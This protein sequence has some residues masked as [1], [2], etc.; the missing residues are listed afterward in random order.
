MAGAG[1]GQPIYFR[2]AECR[3]RGAC[4]QGEYT[5]YRGTRREHTRHVLPTCR[6]FV[7][8]TGRTK[9]IRRRGG[10]PRM[11][12]TAREYTCSCGHTGWSGHVDLERHRAAA[13]AQG[14][15]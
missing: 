8:L 1:T 10:G 2:C 13:E 12:N 9:P 7:R 15:A 4:N 5:T 14:P 11:T 3:R 6:H